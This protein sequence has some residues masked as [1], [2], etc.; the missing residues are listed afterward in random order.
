MTL[1]LVT[2]SVLNIQTFGGLISIT[3]EEFSFQSLLATVK[4]SNYE[5][6]SLDK[7]E[8]HLVIHGPLGLSVM[9]SCCMNANEK[10]EENNVT[11]S[12]LENLCRSLDVPL[13]D[14]P[15]PEEH[16]PTFPNVPSAPPLIPNLT[17]QVC[18]LF[19]KLIFS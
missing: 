16:P 15:E 19:W 11:V 1:C 18:T 6:K 12:F 9:C 13:E 3:K 14:I 4:S 2:P 10:V 8:K 17:L 7:E 5:W